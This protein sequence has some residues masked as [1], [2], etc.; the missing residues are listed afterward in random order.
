MN[1][2]QLTDISKFLSFVLRH[3][4]E[5]IGLQLDREGWASIDSVLAGAITQPF[6]LNR[7]ILHIVVSKFL[8]MINGFAPSKGILRQVCDENTWKNSRLNFSTTVLSSAFS[9]PY[10]NKA[11]TRAPDTMCTC[12]PASKQQ[13]LSEKGAASLLF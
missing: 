12:Q 5:S 4:P 2:K 6:A 11:Y 8:L 3:A 7:E 10:W 1:K 13:S 9:T